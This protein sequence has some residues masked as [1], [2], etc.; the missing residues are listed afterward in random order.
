MNYPFPSL[1]L[2]HG[3]P[4][5][6]IE[7]NSFTRFLKRAASQ[8]TVPQAI[9]VISAHWETRGTKILTNLK[10]KTIHDFGG[11]PD[12][13]Y[14]IQYPAPGN[15]ILAHEISKM[16]GIES[17]DSWGL[18]HGAWSLLVHLYPD[19]DLPVLQLSLDQ[20]LSFKAHFDLAQSLKHLRAQGV[21]VIGS[22]NL[23]HNLRELDWNNS[24]RVFDWAQ[25]FDQMIKEALIQRDL[26]VL[27]GKKRIPPDLWR[28]AHPSLEH[29]L[30]LLYS[31]GMSDESEELSFLFEGFQLGSL[32]M[33]SIALGR[34]EQY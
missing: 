13:L 30:P 23:T 32:S 31:V 34:L 26:A 11:F 18:D 9:L 5:N 6:A 25:D 7:D 21:L 14:E 33:R 15:P 22:G 12:R 4:M 16:K 24:G 8:W 28:R 3:S 29:Y 10:P 27:L 2:A 17:D 1:F 20:S 19:A